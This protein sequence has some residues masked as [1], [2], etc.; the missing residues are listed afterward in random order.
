MS[1]AVDRFALIDRLSAHLASVNAPTGCG[2][3]PNA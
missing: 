3:F 2:C 1:A